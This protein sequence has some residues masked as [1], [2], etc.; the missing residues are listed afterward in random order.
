MTIYE[1][2]T[3]MFSDMK[4]MAEENRMKQIVAGACILLLLAFI[5]GGV[6][7]GAHWFPGVVGEWISMMVGL[8]T[9][10]VF[11]EISSFLGGLLL[12]LV[13]NHWRA[14]RAGDEWVYLEQ[15]KGPEVPG[16]MPEHAKWAVYRDKP[17]DGEIP[18]LQALAEGAL[19]IRDFDGA[20]EWIS[21]MSGEELKLPEVL[22]LRFELA[23]ATGRDALAAQLERE[24]ANLERPH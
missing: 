19:A 9:T 6:V 13:I 8:M 23:K 4:E 11:L 5:V 24:L 14:K 2:G 16:N 21:R 12:V 20:A 18:G 7:M 15:V 17:L 10:P 3:R 1:T 22:A